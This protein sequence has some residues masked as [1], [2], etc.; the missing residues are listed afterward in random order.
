MEKKKY[1]HHY[2]ILK[3]FPMQF[4]FETKWVKEGERMVQ[5]T[6]KNEVFREGD[7]NQFGLVN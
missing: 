4:K 3:I 2:S 6:I 7:I 1:V 5:A